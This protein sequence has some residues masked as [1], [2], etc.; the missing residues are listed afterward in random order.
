MGELVMFG[1]E[2]EGAD[3]PAVI[4]A[5][6]ARRREREISAASFS[7]GGCNVWNDRALC[8]DLMW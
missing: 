8:G 3:E 6:G 4:F 1:G 2:R 7:L 5:R